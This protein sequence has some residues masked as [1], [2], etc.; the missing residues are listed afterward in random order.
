MAGIQSPRCGRTPALQ[1][2]PSGQPLA[3]RLITNHHLT[4]LFLLMNTTVAGSLQPWGLPP[5]WVR[6][7]VW[8]QQ[9]V[10]KIPFDGATSP[11]HNLLGRFCSRGPLL[12]HYRWRMMPVPC[13]F[14]GGVPCTCSEGNPAIRSNCLPKPDVRLSLVL[15]K[16][17]GSCVTKCWP[18][19]FVCRMLNTPG[20]ACVGF[21]Y[22]S[23]DSLSSA[24]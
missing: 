15:G 10:W 24:A 13:P 16:P 18:G 12:L 3:S 2:S 19:A 21:D 9:M 8:L 6:L 5:S 1:G 20:A 14:S 11:P 4:M 17:F 7:T 22:G 23:D